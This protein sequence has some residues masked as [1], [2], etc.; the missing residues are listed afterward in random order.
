MGVTHSAIQKK[1]TRNAKNVA[2][3]M[4][5]RIYQ[6]VDST[7]TGV[8]KRGLE[9]E[10]YRPKEIIVVGRVRG[11]GRGK[12]H[13]NGRD[14][15]EYRMRWSLRGREQHGPKR[16]KDWRGERAREEGDKA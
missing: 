2:N 14:R 10:K 12:I 9:Q 15:E 7:Q 16:E 13:R 5:S 11:N 1:H 4:H 8:E 6:H 3:H